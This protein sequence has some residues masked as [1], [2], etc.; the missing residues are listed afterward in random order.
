MAS[1]SWD[2]E[3][4]PKESESTTNAASPL[5]SKLLS[6]I[7]LSPSQRYMYTQLSFAQSFIEGHWD[8]I[9]IDRANKGQEIKLFGPFLVAVFPK[10]VTLL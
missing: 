6:C 7:F 8:P 4:V 10:L 9:F 5:L 3:G 2:P 1:V